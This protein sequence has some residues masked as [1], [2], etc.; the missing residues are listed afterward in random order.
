MNTAEK[1]KHDG[2]DDDV[3]RP[4]KTW[5]S[6]YVFSFDR[7]LVS[8][9]QIF[10]EKHIVGFHVSVNESHGMNSIEG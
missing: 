10:T 7:K 6:F 3:R 8:L 1:M 2:D 4:S 5:N 9:K